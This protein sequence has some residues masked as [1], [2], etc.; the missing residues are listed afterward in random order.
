MAPTEPPFSFVGFFLLFS[1]SRQPWPALLVIVTDDYRKDPRSRHG[2]GEAG[3]KFE[4]EDGTKLE[5]LHQEN[6]GRHFITDGELH[7]LYCDGVVTT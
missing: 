2:L 6:C 1:W 5:W 7:A 3:G 4:N